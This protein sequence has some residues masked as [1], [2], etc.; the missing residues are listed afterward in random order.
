MTKLG[1]RDRIRLHMFREG[2]QQTD[3]VRRTKIPMT[4]ISQFLNGWKEL[5]QKHVVKFC[6]HLGIDEDAF[7]RERVKNVG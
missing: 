4:A 2:I 7:R 5:P 3:I 6:K 1:F